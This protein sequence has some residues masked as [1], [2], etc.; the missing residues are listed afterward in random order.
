MRAPA[1]ANTR[2]MSL[3]NNTETLLGPALLGMEPW[4]TVDAGIGTTDR[5]I[6][7]MKVAAGTSPFTD[8]SFV[9]DPMDPETYDEPAEKLSAV[10]DSTLEITD[11]SYERQLVTFE[12]SAD[13]IPGS[14]TNV[15]DILFP[16]ASEDWDPFLYFAVCTST[17][18]DQADQAS[19]AGNVADDGTILVWGQFNTTFDPVT[20]QP[21]PLYIYENDQLKIPAGSLLVGLL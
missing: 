11:P 10:L 6:A 21:V 3:S 16:V 1:P 2:C 7:I 17:K 8:P 13:G 9:P 14:Y 5:Y 15:D 4:S 12:P 19:D 18:A 20:Y